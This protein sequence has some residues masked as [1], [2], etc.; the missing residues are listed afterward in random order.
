[1]LFKHSSPTGRRSSTAN[2]AAHHGLTVQ[3]AA[4]GAAFGDAVGIA[5]LNP[6]AAQLQTVIGTDAG[7][8]SFSPNTVSG[9]VANALID[10]ATGQYT[11]G[12]PIGALPQHNLL[13]GEAGTPVGQYDLTIN[14][15]APPNFQTN[16]PGATFVANPSSNVLGPSN[17]LNAGD[18]LVSTV[19]DATINIQEV[20]SV[21]GNP[22]F[23]TGV[24]MNGIKTANILN[25]SAGPGGFAGSV[26]GLTAVNVKGGTNGNVQVGQDYAGLIAALQSVSLSANTNLTAWIAAAALAPLNNNINIDLHGVDASLDL[27]GTSGTNHYETAVIN[28]ADAANVFDFDVNGTSLSKISVVGNQALTMDAGSTALNIANLHNSD[29]SAA[30][31]PLTIT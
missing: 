31:G 18:N 11:T 6:T 27:L 1:M 12:T 15:D 23:A 19:G 10:V 5:L 24:T 3:Q 14:V 7:V 13:Q 28:S 4:Y 20:I 17:T 22:A 29:G 25:S 2:P 8:N 26:T 9:I 30:T 16:V 21:S